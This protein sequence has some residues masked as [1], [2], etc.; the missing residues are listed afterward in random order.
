MMKGFLH[1]F[2]M[3]TIAIA[4]LQTA[5]AQGDTL[6]QLQRL[7]DLYSAGKYEQVLQ[8]SQQL[9]DS[10]IL[11][12][13]EN[14]QR[15]KFT[16]AAYKD[17]GYRREADSTA[18]LFFEKDPFYEVK[19][20]DPLPFRA[21]LGNYY[22]MPKFSVWMAAGVRMVRPVLHSMRQIV[23]TVGNPEYDI[24]GYS[25]QIGFEYSPKRML[26]ISIAPSFAKYQIERK[27]IRSEIA[28]FRYNE[29]CKVFELPVIAEMM[30]YP[31]GNDL[32]PSI[33]GGAQLKY[34][35]ATKSNAYTDAIGT[36]TEVPAKKDDT[37]YKNR[38]N[39]SVLG[40][41]RLNYN[42]R[43]ITFFVDF[44][45]SYDIKPYNDPDKKFD[46]LTLM[47]NNLYIRD[48]FSMLEYT[49]KIGVKVNLQY[50]TIAKHHYG[51]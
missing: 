51:Y 31:W 21:T 30:M 25:A 39:Y 17:F 33:Y 16:V 2:L 10:H 23:D 50:T 3:M 34:I 11:S 32:V 36:Y 22:T 49:A 24:N 5:H 47:Y 46:D 18:R 45:V 40:G 15:L 12:K 42:H 9:G 1:I 26:S 35:I 20:D 38:T 29:S 14:L 6:S 48:V 27:M 13:D 4:A 44:G 19:P 28:T 37:D 43:R 41:A 7:E 8:L